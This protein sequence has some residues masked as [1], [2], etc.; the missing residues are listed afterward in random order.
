LTI[1]RLSPSENGHLKP[2]EAV[3][4]AGLHAYSTA[5]WVPI[6]VF[7][8]R[9]RTDWPGFIPGNYGV[10]FGHGVMDWVNKNCFGS[11]S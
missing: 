10:I 2:F 7:P 5:A 6:V 3:I 8:A 9:I 1:S 4:H 11:P